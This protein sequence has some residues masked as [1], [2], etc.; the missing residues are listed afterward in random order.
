VTALEPVVATPR[1]RLELITPD[2]AAAMRAGLRQPTWHADFPREDDL[3]G[4]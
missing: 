4:I 2:E 1:L 3:D